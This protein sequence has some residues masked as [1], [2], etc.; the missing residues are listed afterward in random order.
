SATVTCARSSNIFIGLTLFKKLASFQGLAGR[1][2]KGISF[3]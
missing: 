3:N 1:A 2:G